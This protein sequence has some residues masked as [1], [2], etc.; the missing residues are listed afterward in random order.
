[1]EMHSNQ[2]NELATALAKFQGEMP[3][4][5]KNKKATILT[6]SGSSYSYKYA[7]LTGILDSVRPNL[8]KHGLSTTQ[9]FVDYKIIT[10][11]MHSSGQ[12]ISS[13]LELNC[14]E[15]I[16]PQEL[17]S[18]ITYM[19]RYAL[20]SILGISADE[21]DDCENSNHNSLKF[22][23]K[24]ENHVNFAIPEGYDH[25]KVDQYID[26]LSKHYGKVPSTIKKQAMDNPKSFWEAYE[27]WLNKK[28]KTTSTT[29]Q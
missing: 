2:I 5:V 14:A 12:F 3:Q 8:S 9:I 4:V 22:R 6:K 13:E 15:E 21:D 18:I 20:V 10:M 11:L 26:G 24:E 16:K 19:R 7:D 23:K 1:M 27:A 29:N 28:E 17:G 25:K